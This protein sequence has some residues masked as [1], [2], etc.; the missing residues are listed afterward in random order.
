MKKL[1]LVLWIAV[2]AYLYWAASL[3]IHC[4]PVHIEKCSWTFSIEGEVRT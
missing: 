1:V 2:T 3:N 4:G